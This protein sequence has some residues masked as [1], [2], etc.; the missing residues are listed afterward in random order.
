M[1]KGSS[2][3][4]KY[5]V[6]DIEKALANYKNGKKNISS[7]TNSTLKSEL[8]HIRSILGEEIVSKD[9]EAVSNDSQTTNQADTNSSS[10]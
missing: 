3:S 1:Y 7:S 4:K 5:L 8:K 2:N 10:N 6:M 9:E